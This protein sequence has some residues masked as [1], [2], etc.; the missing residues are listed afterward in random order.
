MLWVG[1]WVVYLFVSLLVYVSEGVVVRIYP[2]VRRR[3][4]VY[5]GGWVGE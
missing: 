4:P 5:V 2:S 3:S 1:G